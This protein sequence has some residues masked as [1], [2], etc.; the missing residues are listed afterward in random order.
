MYTTDDRIPRRIER[1]RKKL[2]LLQDSLTLFTA[3]SE[4][5]APSLLIKQLRGTAEMQCIPLSSSFN[6]DRTKSWA[7]CLLR[8]NVRRHPG[9]PTALAAD[10]TRKRKNEKKTKKENIRF[11]LLTFAYSAAASCGCGAL[12]DVHDSFFADC[13]TG[14]QL[15]PNLHQR[16]RLFAST[17]FF[18]MDLLFEQ[19][20]RSFWTPLCLE[21]LKF[22]APD[23]HRCILNLFL[24][25]SYRGPETF[26]DNCGDT[27]RLHLSINL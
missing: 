18:L 4:L 3:P 1:L 26:T 15:P 25:D 20:K 10:W 9:H 21:I 23:G 11:S 2:P 7:C 5:I 17:A 14:A 8:F 19:S 22:T 12:S 13:G 6:F 16:T 27:E 24:I